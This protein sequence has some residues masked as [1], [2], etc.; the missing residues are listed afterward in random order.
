MKIESASFNTRTA[1]SEYVSN[2]FAPIL[3]GDILDVGCFEAPLRDLLKDCKYFGVDI[4]GR[5]NLQLNIDSAEPLPFPDNSRDCVLCIE[6]LEHLENLHH[7]FDELVRISR[8]YILVSLP[9]CWRDARQPIARG[10]GHF[11]HYGL[12]LQKPQDRHRWFFSHTEAREFLEHQASR[13]HL[14]LVEMFATEPHRSPLLRLLRKARFPGDR[15]LN[16]YAQTT[17]ALFSK[18]QS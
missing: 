10:R 2:R 18:A 5:P 11:A 12:P 8:Q 17:W 3:R 14:N 13:H 1:R 15:Y 7:V 6:V 16:R 9:N 4:A